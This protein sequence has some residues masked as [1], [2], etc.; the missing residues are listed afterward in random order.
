MIR[1]DDQ[2]V[3]VTGAGAGL[4]RSHA[5]QF[6]ARGAKV[7]VN[8]FGGATDGTGGDAGPADRVVA[9]IE[10]AGGE[11]IANGADVSDY[12]AVEAMVAQAKDKWGRVDVLVANAGILRDKSFAKMEMEDFL[13]VVNVHLIGSANCAEAGEHR[14][15]CENCPTVRSDQRADVD[16]VGHADATSGQ[17]QVSSTTFARSKSIR[18]WC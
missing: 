18:S 10:A 16:R 2:V 15:D 9:E 5:L 17:G 1:F 3:I 4:G 8:D 7:V 14:V 13:K 12:A 11:A 6:A